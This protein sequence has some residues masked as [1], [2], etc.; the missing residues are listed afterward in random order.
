[1][2]KTELELTIIKLS[3]DI[4]FIKKLLIK[5]LLIRRRN[6]NLNPVEQAI[7]EIKEVR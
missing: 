2:T 5:N 1:M 4:E 3:D 7:E 6:G